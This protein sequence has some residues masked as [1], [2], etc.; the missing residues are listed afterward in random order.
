M[1]V[2]TSMRRWRGRVKFW[3]R[4]KARSL[5]AQ[6]ARLPRRRRRRIS[7]RQKVARG[8]CTRKQF[9]KF[10][11]R[12]DARKQM[13]PLKIKAAISFQWASAI[14]LALIACCSRADDWPQWMGPQRDGVWREKGVAEKF[15][16][17][18]PPVLS[19]TMVNT[20][21][22]G[23]SVAAGQRFMLDH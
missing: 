19:P 6:A 11:T 10:S 23:A 8:S 7:R 18:G 21:Y 12:A 17:D 13:E 20:A 2:R 9:A 22:C 16:V 3:R 15:S 14:S 1:C 5:A 4:R